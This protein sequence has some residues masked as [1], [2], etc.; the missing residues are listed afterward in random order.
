[1][2][3]R[4]FLDIDTNKNK[5]C[6]LAFVFLVSIMSKFKIMW[7]SMLLKTAIDSIISFYNKY[8]YNIALLPYGFVLI[9]VLKLPIND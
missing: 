6:E 3:V 4:Q 1:M 5:V 2:G 7:I 9:F 8:L